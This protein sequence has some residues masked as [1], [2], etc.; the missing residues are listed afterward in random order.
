MTIGRSELRTSGFVALERI[1]T[2]DDVTPLE[3]RG[4]FLVGHCSLS[5]LG[6]GSLGACSRHVSFSSA[7]N[8]SLNSAVARS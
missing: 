1:V 3:D 2:E 7:P 4:G 6:W 8:R 5:V